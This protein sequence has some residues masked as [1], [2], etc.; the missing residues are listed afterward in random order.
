[1]SQ[2]GGA[3]DGRELRHRAAADFVAVRVGDG[4]AAQ[5]P[6]A[7]AAIER[8]A[9]GFDFAL[10]QPPRFDLAP[11]RVNIGPIDA[12]ARARQL[13]AQNRR[14]DIGR[15]QQNPARGLQR[16]FGLGLGWI[17][18]S[19]L[20]DC[21]SGKRARQASR[22]ARVNS[23]Q[24]TPSPSRPAAAKTRPQGSTI[25]DSPK[26]RRP[27]GCVPACAGAT[28]KAR[29][30]TARAR[31]SKRQCARPVCGG[32]GRRG[33]YDIGESHARKHRRKTQ[34]ITNAKPDP[35]DCR[36]DRARGA[37][38]FHRARLV[39]GFGFAAITEQ[40]NLVVA[41]EAAAV[42]REKQAGIKN[43]ARVGRDRNRAADKINIA[44]SGGAREKILHRPCAV[45]LGEGEFRVF[46]RRQQR[47]KFGQSDQL[48][49]P[50]GGA[51]D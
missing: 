38:R 48:R 31:A 15:S 42:G 16:V 3:G 26:V 46:G 27:P 5:G 21:K 32:E 7:D 51:R 44:S 30:S 28:T 25:N 4:L 24:T 29:L 43:A 37:P 20:F 6:Q 19:V 34:I 47:K 40:M 39:D 22:R 13:G 18:C 10:F 33:D 35:S 14:V 45:G 17:H 50:I 36:V 11:L 23:A 12:A 41:R 1:M 9:A 2:F 49:A 8:V